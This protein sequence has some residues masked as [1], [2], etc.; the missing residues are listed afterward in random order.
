MKSR[1]DFLRTARAKQTWL[2]LV[3]A[4]AIIRTIAVKDFF[5]AYGI[6]P[7]IYLVIDLISSIPYAHFSANLLI[8]FLD[9]HWESLTKNFLFTTIFFYVPD[10]YIFTAARR[11]PNQLLIGFIIS[12][13]FFSAIAIL[14]F[15]KKIRD[16]RQ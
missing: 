16:G 3:I 4:W 9:I 14:G 2:V 12:V 5:S 13:L 11:I 10:L 7:W 6:H 8:S 15:I 1:I